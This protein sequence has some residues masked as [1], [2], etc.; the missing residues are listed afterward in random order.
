MHET[1]KIM[2]KRVA[3]L[4]VVALLSFTALVGIYGWHQLVDGERLRAEAMQTRLRDG[5]VEAKRGTIYD[6]N[7]NELAKSVS[8]DS[9]YANPKQ[10]KDEHKSE[11][12]DKI[13]DALGLDREAVYAKITQD[14][15]FVWLK[16]R[17][18]FESSQKIKALRIY[19]RDKDKEY[20][21][22]HLLEENKRSYIQGDLAAHLLGFVGDDHQGLTGFESIKDVE[23]RGVP[24]RIVVE[25]NGMGKDIPDAIHEYIPP[26]PGNNL[27]L[28]ID[29]TIQF[30]VEKELDKIVQKYSPELAVII[31]S[32]V[33]TGEILAMGNRPSY[34]PAHW[35][36]YP[37]SVWD[38]NPAIWYS[39][40]PG[41]TFKIITAAAAINDGVVS[42]GDY[43]YCPGHFS[44]AGYDIRCWEGQGH[45][46]QSFSRMVK[47]SC[48]PGFITVGLRL[49]KERFYDYIDAFGFNQSTG[50]D[51]PGEEL[52]I[53][54]DRSKATDLNIATIS[55]GQSIAVTP[56]QLLS[57][58]SAVANQ[59]VLMRPSLVKAITDHEGEIVSEFTPVEVR[60]VIR[61]E[62]ADTLMALLTE[63]VNDGTGVNAFVDGYGSAGKTG[64][65]QMVGP[66]GGYVSGRY[67]TS[68]VGFAPA[69][70]PEVACLVLVAEPKGRND[71]FGSQVAAPV[72]KTLMEDTL[73]Y[74]NVPERLECDTRSIPSRK[75]T[76]IF[77]PSV[78]D[79]P[80]KDAEW[81]LRNAG[82]NTKFSGLGDV[83]TS[84]EPPGGEI[85][86]QGATV[87][88]ELKEA[89]DE[90][91]ATLPDLTGLTIKEAGTLLE[92]LGLTLNPS[93]TGF[94]IEQETNPGE[95]V[96]KG[97]S[98]AVKFDDYYKKAVPPEECTIDN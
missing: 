34:D 97:M 91:E 76:R 42:Q 2:R 67:V 6:R 39:Y 22:A 77:V 14:V 59:G 66:G 28:T 62:T 80:A 87:L 45:S 78:I 82:F 54:I 18:D 15:G 75:G 56:I 16:R 12:A 55:I 10:I 89:E 88:I 85:L 35:Q 1:S 8:V 92:N 38:R 52:G 68:F 24:G 44:I 70:T 50:I 7:G 74:L 5:E 21:I 49:G 37:Q 83:V 29:Q 19:D 47:N 3:V 27:I 31:V 64:T 73:R 17:I 86:P 46:S 93:G 57:A 84:Q 79:F 30:F 4:L 43:F 61:K 65:A 72:F 23:L 33:K 13:A 51:L 11:A 26:V 69:E 94:A 71:F 53:R 96:P 25:K 98:V 48:N 40:E 90:N 63:V 36:D 95:K 9:A 32:D 41:S 20:K 60:R 81:V 58:V